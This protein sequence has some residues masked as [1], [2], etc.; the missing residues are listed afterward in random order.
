VAIMLGANTEVT[1]ERIA[2]MR[3]ELG[4]DKPLLEQYLSWVARALHGDFGTSIW[5]GRPV[6]Q[7]IAAQIWPTLELTFLALLFGA[8]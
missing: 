3:A 2:A 6:I 8:V 5:T 7:E 4:L 1:P